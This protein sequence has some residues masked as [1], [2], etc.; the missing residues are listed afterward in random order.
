MRWLFWSP[1]K[2]G[3]ASAVHGVSCDARTYRGSSMSRPA[4]PVPLASASGR[5]LSTAWIFVLVVSAAGPFS[6]A[7]GTTPLAFVTGNGAGL[8]AAY[9]AVTLLMLC[10]AVGYAAV[11]R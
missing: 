1:P 7:V 3:R 2:V 9:L 5:R 6:S 4:P 11:S 10:F 8:P